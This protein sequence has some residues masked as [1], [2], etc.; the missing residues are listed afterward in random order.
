MYILYGGII[1]DFTLL[2]LSLLSESLQG[3]SIHTNRNSPD[4]WYLLETFTYFYEIFQLYIYLCITVWA[5][6][7]GNEA[8]CSS[9]QWHEDWEDREWHHSDKGWSITSGVTEG[10][11]AVT[12]Q[13]QS[14]FDLSSIMLAHPLYHQLRQ[15]G[16]AMPQFKILLQQLG[17]CQYIIFLRTV[18]GRPKYVRR[19]LYFG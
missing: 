9:V 7:S 10:Q 17:I 5:L 4:I 1:I 14:C 8:G 19:I 3:W 16:R 13:H 6:V 11:R 2:C 18:I 12:G 15:Q